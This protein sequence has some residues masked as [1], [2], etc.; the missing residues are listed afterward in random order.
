MCLNRNFTD[1]TVDLTIV[2]NE[3]CYVSTGN[4]CGKFGLDQNCVVQACVA[5]GGYAGKR[6]GKRNLIAVQIKASPS[7]QRHGI[8][9]ID[10]LVS[11]GDG[12]RQAIGEGI[13]DNVG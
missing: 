3:A 10:S 7:I 8:A 1:D 13:N 6:P 11:P 4:I 5:I 9:G 12:Y 2:D